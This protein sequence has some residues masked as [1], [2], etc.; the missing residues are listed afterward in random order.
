MSEVVIEPGAAMQSV[1]CRRF[2][3]SEA[4]VL[5]AGTALCLAAGTP[6]LRLLA[7]ATGHLWAAVVTHR[8]ELLADPTAFWRGT[9]D[10]LRNT[11]WYCSVE[12]P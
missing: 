6:F 1:R 5:I 7:N 10:L 3:L 2:G 9:H 8:V 12:N 11:V 4:M